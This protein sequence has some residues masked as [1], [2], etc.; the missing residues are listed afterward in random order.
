MID[1]DLTWLQRIGREEKASA[2]AL[3]IRQS[4]HPSNEHV[5]PLHDLHRG[6]SAPMLG[7]LLPQIGSDR[8]ASASSRVATS[9]GG[10]ATMGARHATPSHRS[11]WRS[12]RSTSSM[13]SLRDKVAQ[14]VADEV[15]QATQTL[16]DPMQPVDPGA[17][18]RRLEALLVQARGERVPIGGR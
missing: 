2:K 15:L 1:D 12:R 13:V 8:C 5:E 10:I 11:S 18:R 6:F 14:S 4:M 17:R 7:G 9:A 3:C 16:T